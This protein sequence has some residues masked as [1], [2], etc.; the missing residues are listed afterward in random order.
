[1]QANMC[2]S[3]SVLTLPLAPG[4]YGH[5][6]RPPA[7][8]SKRVMP[9]CQ[10]AIALASAMPRVLCRCTVSATLGRRTDACSHKAATCVGYAMPVVS[11]RVMPVAPAS[12]SRA[13]R[14]S[15]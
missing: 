7:A 6:P 10:A 13:A 4:A 1:M 3:S 12:A 9:V 2:T 8:A 11:H 5:P 15:T 14:S